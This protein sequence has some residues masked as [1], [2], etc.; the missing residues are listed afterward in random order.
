MR[1]AAIT[2]ALFAVVFDARAA[3]PAV[4]ANPP[5]PFDP[6]FECSSANSAWGLKYSGTVIDRDGNIWNFSDRGKTLPIATQDHGV[7]VYAQ[8]DLQKKYTNATKSGSVEATV[9]AEK[10]A[11]IEKAAGGTI[12]RTDTGARDAGSS[13]CHAYILD[14]TTKRFRD[15]NLGSDA[16]I[17][18]MRTANSAKEAQDLIV[19][20]KS[21]GVAH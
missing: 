10:T 9:L 1:Y 7:P 4:P 15:I 13:A 21:V 14:A 5:V 8:A 11:L 16:G 2:I 3:D 6:L 19:W 12:T 20:L 17:T 18:D